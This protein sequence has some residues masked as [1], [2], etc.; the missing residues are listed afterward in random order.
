MGANPHWASDRDRRSQP[1][2][3]TLM[4]PGC[5]KGCER[6]CSCRAL[7]DP[8]STP[9]E[10]DI[11]LK[12]GSYREGPRSGTWPLIAGVNRQ[13]KGV[14]PVPPVGL[15]GAVGGHLRRQ[16]GDAPV[17]LQAHRHPGHHQP[18]AVREGRLFGALPGEASACDVGV[19]PVVG[20][21]GEGDGGVVEHPAVVRLQSDAV[22]AAVVVGLDTG[23][24]PATVAR[25]V[26][27]GWDVARLQSP[28]RGAPLCGQDV[29]AEVEATPSHSVIQ[30]TQDLLH[31]AL[32]QCSHAIPHLL[33]GSRGRRF[34]SCQPDRQPDR[35][36]P[37]EEPQVIR[38][39]LS[40]CQTSGERPLSGCASFSYEFRF[41]LG[42]SHLVAGVLASVAAR[43][44]NA[45]VKFGGRSSPE[46]P[47]CSRPE[48]SRTR[49]RAV[50]AEGA[51]PAALASAER[52]DDVTSPRVHASTSFRGSR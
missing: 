16:R 42:P 50:H 30:V 22:R 52:P 3:A 37:T 44:S 15:G 27:L 46:M 25:T 23:Y 20:D 28:C 11:F 12:L 36:S 35:V 14:S 18:P 34:K 4:L 26:K 24:K 43:M 32:R 7:G 13:I 33:W 9:V 10:A 48:R 39:R 41:S 29:G 2:A 5:A 19:G 49:R 40:R 51:L 21:G 31:R 17:P 38:G 1:P 47:R 45:L 8:C 6:L